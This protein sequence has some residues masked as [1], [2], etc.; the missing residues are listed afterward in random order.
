MPREPDEFTFPFHSSHP[1]DPPAEYA[2]LRADEPVARA[3]LPNG[4]RVWLVTRYEDVRK[5]FADGRLS[6]QAITAP[7]APKILPIA[8]GS[9]SIFVMDPPEHTRLRRLVANAFTTRQVERLRPRI[10]ELA[11]RMVGRMLEQGPPCDLIEHVAEPLPITVICELLGVPQRDRAVFRDWTEVMLSFT[12]HTPEQIRSAVGQLRGYLAELVA[13]KQRNPAD[14]LLTSLVEARDEDDALSTEELLAFGQTMLVA[15]Y[16][17]TSAEIAHAVLNLV[18]MPDAVA[19]LA[20]DPARLPVAIEELLRY[21][22]AGG[23]VG[24]VR[25][26]TEPVR[27]GD[28]TIQPGEAVLPCINSANRDD[29]VFAQPDRLDLDRERNPHVAFGHGVHH[30]LGAQLGR[31]E[32]QVVLETLLRRLG[33]FSLAVEPQELAWRTGTAFARPLSLPLRWRVSTKEGAAC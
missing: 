11:D 23:G 7:G 33:E 18:S 4:H 15:G 12:A 2:A 30:C 28:V 32:L 10:A 6:R 1:L 13:D 29:T 22:Q 24:P 19:R 17:A 25:I 3:T 26:A 5:V 8:T 14:D 20:A 31:V 21:S 16:H 27:V 9:K